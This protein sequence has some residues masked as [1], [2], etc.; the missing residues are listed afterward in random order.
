M[1]IKQS[2]LAGT[3]ESSD[4]MVKI[5]P[6]DKKGIFIELDSSV[7]KQFGGQIRSVIEQTLANLGVVSAVVEA[8]DKGAL[9]CTVQA[10]TVAAVHRAAGMTTYNW[11][12][13][14]SWKL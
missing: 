11:K 12:E 13:I 8:V 1:E 9:D 7:E 5:N 10:R 2:A 6:T 4:I 3:M 14:D